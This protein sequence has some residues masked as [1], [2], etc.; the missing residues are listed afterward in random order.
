MSTLSA[1]SNQIQSREAQSKLYRLRMPVLSLMNE[2]LL[3]IF[4]K[5]KQVTEDYD[6]DY[7][8][9]QYRKIRK[10]QRGKLEL[11]T[12]DIF[13]DTNSEISSPEEQSDR[14]NE[15]SHDDLD[16]N[17]SDLEEFEVTYQPSYRK[18]NFDYVV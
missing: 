10:E 2:P 4:Q 13:R 7:E 9:E 17:D 5:A 11:V 16:W 12:M 8:Y 3:V 18:L 1:F 14:D 15:S 6:Q